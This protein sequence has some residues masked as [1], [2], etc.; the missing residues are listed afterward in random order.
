MVVV[1]PT[2]FAIEDAE[3]NLFKSTSINLSIAAFLL[4]TTYIGVPALS[5]LYLG[6]ILF[7]SA[8][9]VKTLDKLLDEYL[10]LLPL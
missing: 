8:R 6:S 5:T 10:Y 2:F 9:I 1:T 3:G 4:L 7:S